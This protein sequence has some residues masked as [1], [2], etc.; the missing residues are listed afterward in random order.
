MQNQV[1][2]LFSKSCGPSIRALMVLLQVGDLKDSVCGSNPSLKPRRM[3]RSTN[4]GDAENTHIQS[5]QVEGINISTLFSQ[6]TIPFSGNP[7]RNTTSYTL[8]CVCTYLLAFIT[9]IPDNNLTK[10]HWSAL[11]FACLPAA[12]AT[13]ARRHSSSSAIATVTS[14]LWSD[15][16][17]V[18]EQ[19]FVAELEAIE[20]SSVAPALESYLFTVTSTGIT[21][22]CEPTTAPAIVSAEWQAE[23]VSI[24]AIVVSC[25][26]TIAI[27]GVAAC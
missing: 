10:M 26:A 13:A 4:C 23:L 25:L 27:D 16:C 9:L 15:E 14:V 21:N 18:A 7:V 19:S 2:N 11:L 22:Y 8:L 24:D 5:D 3:R 1:D 6:R 20:T 17:L 12:L